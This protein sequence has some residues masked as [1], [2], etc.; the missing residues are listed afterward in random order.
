MMM[1]TPEA[2]Q[3]LLDSSQSAS[4]SPNQGRKQ[5]ARNHPAARKRLFN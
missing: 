1:R 5:K 2:F 3:R 4:P